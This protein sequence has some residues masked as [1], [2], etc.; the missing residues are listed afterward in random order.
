ME[1]FVMCVKYGFITLD[2]DSEEEAIEIAK[3]AEDSDFDWSN[4]DEYQIVEEK[5]GED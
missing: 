4:A 5:N 3:D 1:Y 2:A